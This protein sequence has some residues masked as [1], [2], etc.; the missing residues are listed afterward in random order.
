MCIRQKFS[1]EI[2]RVISHS[3]CT[4]ANALG[5]CSVTKSGYQA[6]ILK[7]DLDSDFT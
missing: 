1:K 4:I 5:R 6:E 2:S 7:R 3:K